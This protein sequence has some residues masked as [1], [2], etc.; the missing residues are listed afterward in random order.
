[1]PM[2][3]NKKLIKDNS[4]TF[5]QIVKLTL[6]FILTNDTFL[7]ASSQGLS[8]YNNQPSLLKTEYNYLNPVINTKKNFWRATAEWTLVQLLPWASNYYIRKADFARISLNTIGN[9]FTTTEWDDNNFF[10]NQFSHPYQGSLYF[11]SFRSNGYSFWESTPAVLAGSFIW[12][13]M[14]EKNPP[15]PNDV[16]NTSFGGI[17]FG[18]MTNRLSKV[19]LRR[20]AGKKKGLSE[21]AAFVI[22]PMQ[23][24]SRLM[25][26]DFK[27]PMEPSFRK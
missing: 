17:I 20:K 18:E 24:L 10:N 13:T 25:D 9:N 22:N 19:I 6:F 8:V 2:I 21:P 7:S 14:L 15:S 27:K 4:I 26:K 1:M 5:Y 11:N 23:G 12:E 16:I 3:E